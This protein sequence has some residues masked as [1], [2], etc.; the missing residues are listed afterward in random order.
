MPEGY[1][2]REAEVEPGI[3][4]VSL[5]RERR[6]WS[7]LGP[8]PEVIEVLARRRFRKRDIDGLTTWATVLEQAGGHARA[9]TLGCFVVTE[10]VEG[11]RVR[12]RLY[13]RVIT[14]TRLH[15]EIL[16]ERYFEAGDADVLVKSAEFAE[17]LREWANRRN[18]QQRSAEIA[19]DE[20]AR[21]RRA[22]EQARAQ[23]A[24]ELAEILNRAGRD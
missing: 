10:P 14:P 2:V 15:T 21:L 24:R 7:L 5:T 6:R 20:D 8:E 19:V 1:H 22:N 17:E 18:E 3:V 9:G 4:E 12:I 13:E 11:G 23:G 16:A